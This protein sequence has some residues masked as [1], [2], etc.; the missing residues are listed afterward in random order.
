MS[1]KNLLT[2]VVLLFSVA[3]FAQK[4]PQGR[5]GMKDVNPE[6][7]AELQTKQ[8]TLA[9]VLDDNQQKKVYDVMLAQAKDRK[10]KMETFKASR[11]EGVRPTEE[12]ML[13][14][15]SQALDTQIAHQ[16]K[17]QKILS[18]EQFKQWR[19][20]KAQHMKKGREN[21]KRKNSNR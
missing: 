10:V 17:M 5:F 3:L 11:E 14:Y 13:A 6:Q 7:F 19:Q 21:F 20:M 9:L 2:G 1:M 16:E 12:E 8:L 18:E 15:R 4:A